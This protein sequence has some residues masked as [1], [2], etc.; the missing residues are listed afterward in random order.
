MPELD[1]VRI[2]DVGMSGEDDP[3]VLAWAAK[4]NRILLSHDVATITRYAYE[5][6]ETGEAMPG[7]IEIPLSLSVGS[8]IED[9]MLMIECSLECEWEGQVLYLPLK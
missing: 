9:L 2:Q 7:V 8:V 5:R 1:I 4:E 6:V 3:S